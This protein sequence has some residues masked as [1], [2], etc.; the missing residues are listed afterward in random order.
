[1]KTYG[2]EEFQ[3]NNGKKVII[4]SWSRDQTEQLS[5]ALSLFTKETA[6]NISDEDTH[7][8]LLDITKRLENSPSHLFLSALDNNKLVAYLSLRQP[9]PDRA[10]SKHIGE[11]GIMLLSDYWS[12]GLGSRLLEIMEKIAK[13]VGITRIEAKFRVKNDRASRL[14]LRH[15]Y[16]IEGKRRHGAFINGEYEDEYFL[17]K[18]LD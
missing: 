9:F 2:P 3:L 14:F 12:Q 7:Y 11:L 8:M 6:E 18:L 5:Q 15:K 1:M 17:S 13:E 4:K 16:Q 10:W